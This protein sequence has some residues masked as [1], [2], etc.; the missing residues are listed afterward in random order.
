MKSAK[1]LQYKTILDIGAYTGLFSLVAAALVN[2]NAKIHAYEPN[3]VTFG[4]F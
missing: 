3:P 1:K 4:F 2:P